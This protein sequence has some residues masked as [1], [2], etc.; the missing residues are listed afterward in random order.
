[1]RIRT[2]TG[3]VF[4]ATMLAA[5]AAW[6]AEGAATTAA[7]AVDET[8]VVE[9]N[10]VLEAL[11]ASGLLPVIRL[12][13]ADAAAAQ[14]GAEASS[15]PHIGL[16]A[17][18]AQ[19]PL[20][21]LTIPGWGQKTAGAH[22]SARVFGLA[23]L[24]IWTSFAAFRIQSQM[25]RESYERT[26]E[27]L[28]HVSMDGRDEEFRRIVG[29]YISS[30]EYN[31]LVVYREAANLH[32][33]DPDAYRQYIA[34]HSVGGA[35]SWSWD[36]EEAFLRYRA[37]RKDAQR[38]GIRANTALACAVVNRLLSLVHAARLPTGAQPRSWNLE[39]SPG[40]SN[41]ALAYRVGVRTRF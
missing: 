3:L 41:D 12:E 10:A 35:D 20:R 40:V 11:E 13:A 16:S 17:E 21:S 28:G 39:V 6:S 14:A 8:S 38:A 33:D 37:Q 30:E 1:M 31:Q 15:S 27:L 25:R 32:Y 4:V 34:E 23:E 9:S 19:L 18:R 2:M 5:T 29:A 26:A 36:S 24:G 7:N 22:T